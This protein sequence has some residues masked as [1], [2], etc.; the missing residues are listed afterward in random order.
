MLNIQYTNKFKK[1]YKK[2][3][4]RGLKQDKL[5]QVIKTLVNEKALPLHYKDHA[6][7]GNYSGYRE[8]HL[9][10]DWLLIYK[11]KKEDELLILIRT[12]THSDLFE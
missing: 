7:T 5:A 12:G 10:P 2:M 8:C 9:A 4:K 1:D 11:M 6:L 3:L